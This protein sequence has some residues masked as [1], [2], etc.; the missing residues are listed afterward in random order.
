MDVIQDAVKAEPYQHALIIGLEMNITGLFFHRF[1]DDGIDKFH[2][3][4]LINDFPESAPIKEGI[5]LLLFSI[6]TDLFNL[7]TELFSCIS[8][9]NGLFYLL[10][11]S[12]GS[13]NCASRYLG[14]IVDIGHFSRIGHGHEKV[15]PIEHERYHFIL[16]RYIVRNEAQGLPGRDKPVKIHIISAVHKFLEIFIFL[17]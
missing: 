14:E 10:Y 12:I 17:L 8:R 3:R 6:R 5:L 13:V 9:H 15:V 2:H 11:R 16:G 4:A 1:K 7:G